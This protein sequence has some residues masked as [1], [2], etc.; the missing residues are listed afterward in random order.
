[1]RWPDLSQKRSECE[2]ERLNA[3]WDIDLNESESD[4]SEIESKID[5]LTTN[6]ERSEIQLFLIHAL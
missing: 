5:F 2:C 3:N 6:L 4:L 1:M